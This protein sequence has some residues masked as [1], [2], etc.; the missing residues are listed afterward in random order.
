MIIKIYCIN[1]LMV[2]KKI[3]HY[4]KWRQD[5]ISKHKQ[6]TWKKYQKY[7][8]EKQGNFSSEIHYYKS[9]P[10][11]PA[12]HDIHPE[13]N[14]DKEHNEDVEKKS[15]EHKKDLA[16][17]LHNTMYAAATS[18]RKIVIPSHTNITVRE[19]EQAQYANASKKYDEHIKNGGN[20]EGALKA[21]QEYLNSLGLEQHKIS[22][23]SNKD[24]LVI[25]KPNGKIEISYRGTD[26]K[27]L[28]DLKTDARLI[29]GFEEGGK[30]YIRSQEQIANVIAEHGAGSIDHFSGYSKGGGQALLN[31]AKHNIEATGINPLIGKNLLKKQ[32]TTKPL[33]VLRTVDDPASLGLVASEHPFEMKTIAPIKEGYV[34]GIEPISQS[35]ATHRLENFLDGE[36]IRTNGVGSEEFHKANAKSSIATEMEMLHTAKQ[37]YDNGGSY[38]DYIH[39]LYKN[40]TP[41][42]RSNR[43]QHQ[44]HSIVDNEKRLA[45]NSHHSKDMK[46]R[47]WDDVSNGEFTNQE[48]KYIDNH[49]NP[50]EDNSHRPTTDRNIMRDNELARVRNELNEL[51]AVSTK[52]KKD[53][54]AMREQELARVK[55]ELSMMD[56]GAKFGL[57][58]GVSGI[59]QLPKNEMME[60]LQTKREIKNLGKRIKNIG[61]GKL[62]TEFKNTIDPLGIIEQFPSVPTYNPADVK[63]LDFPSV[64]TVNPLDR[65]IDARHP[66]AVAYEGQRNF[67][68]PVEVPFPVGL[69]PPPV[70]TIENQTDITNRNKKIKD[71]IHASRTQH[72]EE[73]GDFREIFG[74]GKDIHLHHDER[75]SFLELPANERVNKINQLH[76][77][78]ATHAN[79]SSEHFSAGETTVAPSGLKQLASAF[80][81]TSVAMGLG[82]GIAAESAMNLIDKDHKIPKVPRGLLVGGAAG[83]MG[84]L[85]ARGLGVAGEKLIERGALTA[86]TAETLGIAAGGVGLL[87][88]II[89]GGA[90]YVAGELGGMGVSELVKEAGGDKNAQEWG[91]SVGGGAIGGATSG[92][93]IGSVVPGIG[94]AIGAGIGFVG[95]AAFGALSNS[96]VFK[97]IGNLFS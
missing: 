33:N 68:L 97:S 62:N 34:G 37:V 83:G 41:T 1:I 2:K 45:G 39:E 92:A 31:G 22:P 27:H 69:E 42:N 73:H 75:T 47:S 17:G 58:E 46:V 63:I 52:I 36:A 21:S 59:N 85:V 40:E 6:I 23:L 9:H 18:V 12:K 4:N 28:G 66:N 55:Q 30:Q 60:R 54:I 29:G 35:Y 44:P 91:S 8:E 88:E 20:D 65:M 16:D 95:G 14:S 57:D 49:I 5:Q 26:K 13:T 78:A 87:P 71:E 19:Q 51:P 81:P 11:K 7:V 43:N 3:E 15:I 94:T 79:N 84:N 56:K 64:P 10:V 76:T 50:Y 48:I 77:E 61:E 32:D 90:G 72:N 93:I 89:A 70:P 96:G 38:T 25:E 53:R 82:A 80:H 86:G 24:G 74:E 67:N